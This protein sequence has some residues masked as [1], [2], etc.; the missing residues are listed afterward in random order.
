MTLAVDFLATGTL[1]LDVV[2]LGSLFVH[3]YNRFSE[4][5]LYRYG[6]YEKLTS[7]ISAYYREIAV[8]VALTATTG[9]LY[10][11]NVLGWEPCRLCW[12][13]RIFMYP[14]VVI[15]AV[16]IFFDKEQVRDYV[17]PLSLI[18]LPISVYHYAIQRVE[19]FQAAGC[20]VTAVSCSTEY[21]FHFGYITIPMMAATAFAV[22]LVLVWRFNSD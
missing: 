10:L 18:G 19:Q 1:I 22:I 20:S 3:L 4:Q 15:L 17:I 11:S 16:A 13:Q 14:L 12:F 9:S 6:F 5:G 7:K 21:T 8:F 2:L